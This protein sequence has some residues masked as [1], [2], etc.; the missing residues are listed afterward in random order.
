LKIFSRRRRE[1]RRLTPLVAIDF[2]AF[3]GARCFQTQFSTKKKKSISTKTIIIIHF[4]YE[5]EE[6]LTEKSIINHPCKRYK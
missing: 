3:T 2:S 1:R 6:I 4:H 5:Y